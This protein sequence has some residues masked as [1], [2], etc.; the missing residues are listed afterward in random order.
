MS[1]SNGAAAVHGGV[2][3][4][5]WFRAAAATGY[6]TA[7]FSVEVCYE[8]DTGVRLAADQGDAN[9]YMPLLTFANDYTFG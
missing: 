4:L 7:Q 2:E 8:N 9:D 5:R 6:A 1:Y 3:T